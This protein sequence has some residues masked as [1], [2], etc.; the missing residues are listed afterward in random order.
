MVRPPLRTL[1]EGG[2]VAVIGASI[3][4]L[5]PSQTNPI[6]GLQTQMSP[7]LIP[8]LVGIGLILTGL[9]LIVQG[10]FRPPEEKPI[11]LD[12]TATLRIVIT[13]LMLIAYSLLFPRV[14][15]VV[16]SGIFVGFF[17]WFFGAR[18]IVKIGILV[19]VTPVV[20]WLFF[21]RL[22]LIPV[23]HGFLF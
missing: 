18:S 6:P 13:V 22:F 7:G 16:T 15:F 14:G 1:V 12:R 5:V 20:V 8:T 10:A 17:S 3:V 19:V 9:G 21:E 11:G 2:A 4:I 23:P